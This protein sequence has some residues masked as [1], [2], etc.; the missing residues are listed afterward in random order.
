MTADW[1]TVAK[2]LLEHPQDRKLAKLMHSQV[3]KAAL[4]G[5]EKSTLRQAVADAKDGNLE[6]A[7]R[8]MEQLLASKEGT[9]LVEQVMAAMSE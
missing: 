9:A 8:V 3:G 4:S 2:E 7:R 1:E 5:M 6:P